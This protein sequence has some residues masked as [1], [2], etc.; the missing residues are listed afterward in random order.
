MPRPTDPQTSAAY[1]TG[2]LDAHQLRKSWVAEASGLSRTSVTNIANGREE[3]G[4]RACALLGVGLH[5]LVP[6]IDPV[7]V[8]GT[9]CFL[10]TCV[11]IPRRAE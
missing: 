5:K 9:L 6:S 8:A 3:P 11:D 2:L 7:E 4:A 1:L 10:A